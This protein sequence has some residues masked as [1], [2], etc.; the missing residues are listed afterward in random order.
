V[1]IS[2]FDWVIC[3]RESGDF[4][5][6]LLSRLESFRVFKYSS[7][8][9]VG[10]QR[11][12]FV[13]ESGLESGLASGKDILSRFSDGEAESSGWLCMIIL[14]FIVVFGNIVVT[15]QLILLFEMTVYDLF[16]L[17]SK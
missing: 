16:A 5:G 10:Q 17:Y 8:A 3:D 2:A 6:V 4:M 7:P 15:G 9:C 12:R 14:Q 13:L 11:L 1:E